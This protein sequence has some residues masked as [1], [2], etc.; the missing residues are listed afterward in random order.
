MD[1]LQAALNYAELG[2]RVFPCV[3]GGKNPLTQ[4]GCN[5]ATT[6]E[7]QILAWWD[8]HPTANVAI[9][10]DGLLVVDR[11]T[12]KTTGK[13]NQWL[14]GDPRLL[15]L[16]G[17]P[18]TV[19]PRGGDHSWF[20]QPLGADFRNSAGK[21]AD[22]VD[23]RANGGYVLVPPS[24]VDNK[25]YTW[26]QEL[27]QSPDRLDTPPDWLLEMIQ[28]G[29]PRTV[30]EQTGP[31]HEG[32]RNDYLTRMAG[33]LRRNG[34]DRDEIAAALHQRNKSRCNPPLT[35]KEVDQIAESVSRYEADQISELIIEGTEPETPS[36]DPGPF[37]AKLLDVP[38][39]IHHV[40]DYNL[41]TA[42][43]RQ[44]ELALAAA[45]ALAGSVFGRKV[46]D[47]RDTRTN[48]YTIG[49][50]ESGGGK[51]NGLKVNRRTLRAAGLSELARFEDPASST[52]MVN[53]VQQS[54]AMLLQID[55]MGRFLATLKDP[56]KNPYLF[57]I[58]TVWMKMFSLANDVY[59]GKAYADIKNE[60]LIIQPNLCIYGTTVRKSFLES[61]TTESLTNGLVSRL[62][63]FEATVDRPPLQ[64]DVCTD[65]PDENLISE[66][67]YWRDYSPGGNLSELNPQPRR[68]ADTAET[69]AFFRQVEE[70]YTEQ[71]QAEKQGSILWTRATEKAR[72][73]A[74]IYQCSADRESTQLSMEACKWAGE[75]V[76]YLTHKT[77]FMAREWIADSKVGSDKNKIIRRL[78]EFGPQSMSQLL[79]TFQGHKSRELLELLN[80][81]TASGAISSN[82]EPT[83]G[84]IRTT[85]KAN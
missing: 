2:Y 83:G 73:L 18:L 35:V 28:G 75:L 29:S 85:Y 59:T 48:I 25:S 52:G 54:P 36:E 44:P 6:D 38:G 47:S 69:K 39:L 78:R 71:V 4:H 24:V 60:K 64:D 17:G 46:C 9:S 45:I 79:R 50:C 5:E 49:L 53:A 74:L 76:Y 26:H 42:D 82:Q 20:R 21:L 27:D 80:D 62:L 57:E 67:A 66:V 7:F 13:T 55:E 81:L 16:F 33:T 56:G 72:K 1:L 14:Q 19:T 32:N 34:L 11:D 15:E 68:V 22:G 51:N 40:M 8:A 23:I 30:T 77:I 12:D 70:Y 63:V 10:T 58:V 37:P 43:R 65:P 41:R 61:L 3:P 31:V 84:R